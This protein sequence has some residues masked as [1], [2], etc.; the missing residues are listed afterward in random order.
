MRRQIFE[1][2]FSIW[3][4]LNLLLPQDAWSMF[5][6]RALLYCPVLQNSADIDNAEACLSLQSKN[7]LYK[8]QTRFLPFAFR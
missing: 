1:L 3:N 2:C 6:P 4:E 8:A 7:H 5:Q